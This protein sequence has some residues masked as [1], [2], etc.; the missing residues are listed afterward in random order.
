MVTLH[1]L[2]SIVRKERGFFCRNLDLLASMTMWPT[3]RRASSCRVSAYEVTR[4][5]LLGRIE[6]DGGLTS[7][8]G[9]SVSNGWCLTLGVFYEAIIAS[10]AR[11]ASDIANIFL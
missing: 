3:A 6:R 11:C 8:V 4:K 2:V 1:V 9:A 7:G 5:V 10:W